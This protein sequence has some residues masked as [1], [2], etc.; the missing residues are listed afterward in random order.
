MC[1]SQIDQGTGKVSKEFKQTMNRK[2]TAILIATVFVSMA[3]FAQ[4]PAASA[5]AG[6]APTKIGIINLQEAIV[7]T[8]EGQRDL[9]VLQDK[10]Q[11][12]RTEL[13]SLS[14]E[15]D[16]LKQQLNTQGDKL[17]D[18]AKAS[19][20][21]N[22]E[23]KQKTYQRT[24]EDAQGDFNNQQGEIANRIGSKLL[25]V[26]DKY[27]KENGYAVVL[28]VSDPQQTSV[29]WAGPQVDLTAQIVTAYNAQSNVPAPAATPAAKAPSATRPAA[30]AKPAPATPPKR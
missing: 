6:P 16:G 27:A 23:F 12:R 10:F 2:F 8:N 5:P 9:K 15:L 19:L 3:A 25:E 14:K 20:A 4:A 30:T 17:N 21:R 7:R 18:E 28:N 29:V 1:S 13:E 24:L 11:P 26:L 22:I